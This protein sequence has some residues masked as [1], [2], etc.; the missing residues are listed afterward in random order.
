MQ[1]KII[2]VDCDCYYA[3]LEMRDFPHLKG[4]PVAVGGIGPR[5]VLSTCNYEARAFGIRSAMPSR[6]A[7]ALCPS[8][9]IQ[10]HRFEV[11]RSVSEQIQQIF[12]RYVSVIEPLSLDEAFLDVTESNWFGGSAT[13]LAEHIRQEIYQETGI[14]VSAGV[15]PNKFLAK[16]SSDWNKPDGLFVVTP[17]KMDEFLVELPVNKINGVGKKFSERLNSLGI[18]T[19][20]D[21]R[22]WAL[23]RLIDQ[24]GK[25]GFWLYQR[26]RGI[27][28]RK[29]G[30]FGTRKS[31][32]IEHTFSN[33]LANE[34]DCLEQ[35]HRLY[36]SLQ[37]RLT[38]RPTPPVKNVFIKVRFNDFKTTT[39]ER[40]LSVEL[41]SF[42]KLL[43]SASLKSTKA[44]RLI[45]LGVRF[46]D[47]AS[48]S[49][50]DLWPEEA[51]AQGNLSVH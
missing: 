33:D 27:D 42:E 25:S 34:N 31:L 20:G 14:T 4:R 10:P 21:I 12:L 28:D 43:K 24:F 23:P 35:I 26:A 51:N 5:S 30:H 8:L 38:K 19:C 29:V 16:V 32:S 7:L 44:I 48:E 13:L 18:Y 1:R 3:A 37:I 15:A 41:S 40:Q 2:H 46:N 6:R 47:S 49:Q 39:M 9:T 45:G 11:Y 22:N 50:L 36:Q 17:E